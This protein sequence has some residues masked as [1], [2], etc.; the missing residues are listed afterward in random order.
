MCHLSPSESGTPKTIWEIATIGNPG[1]EMISRW[2]SWQNCPR[3]WRVM[4]RY[5]WWWT[6]LTKS[7]HFLVMHETLS[8]ERLAKLYVDE[9]IYRHGVPL[10]IVSDWNSR[11]T[12]NFWNGLQKELGTRLS[13]STAY[14][15]RTNGQS[16]RMIQTL[17]DIIFY[18]CKR[19]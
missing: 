18:A 12:S 14:Y 9:V 15:P 8:V 16:K 13:L 4:V 1:V 6:E 3:P 5:G 19:E 2:I 10:S 11:F 7:T 17:K